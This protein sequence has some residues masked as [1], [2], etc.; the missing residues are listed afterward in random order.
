[1]FI[2]GIYLKMIV[3]HITY[4]YYSLVCFMIRS[5]TWVWII[6]TDNCS[7]CVLALL[8]LLSSTVSVQSCSEPFLNFAF[9]FIHRSLFTAPPNCF[10]KNKSQK[11]PK[12]I[13]RII[14]SVSQQRIIQ[15]IYK[16]RFI[17]FCH[18]KTIILQEIS[19]YLS[20]MSIYC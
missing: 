13:D 11:K 20:D 3:W 6:F 2:S 9:N 16:L 7:D 14:Y 1:M 19:F 15:S 4:F 8:S 10:S 12:T 5:S 17:C 18:N